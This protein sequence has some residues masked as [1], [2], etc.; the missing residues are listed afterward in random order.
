MQGFEDIKAV[1]LEAE[2][3]GVENDLMTPSFKLKRAPLLVRAGLVFI[4]VLSGFY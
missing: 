1:H 4:R 2:P 3:F